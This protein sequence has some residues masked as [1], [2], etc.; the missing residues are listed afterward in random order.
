[1]HG[2]GHAHAGIQAPWSLRAEHG[3]E[4]DDFAFVVDHRATQA[5]VIG[6]GIDLD[7]GHPRARRFASGGG[8]DAGGHGVAAAATVLA[9]NGDGVTDGEVRLP[10]NIRLR[11]GDGLGGFEQGQAESRIDADD[12]G[13]ESFIA[14]ALVDDHGSFGLAVQIVEA[15]EQESFG[16]VQHQGAH[17]LIGVK[18]LLHMVIAIPL[19]LE[20]FTLV[21]RGILADGAQ[22]SGGPVDCRGRWV[23]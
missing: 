10:V 4:G 11:Q 1:M 14:Q 3:G 8:N 15:G 16:G 21:G 23:A 5:A 9:E 20:N 2:A 12:L 19:L 7:K 22:G 6:E 17:R 18:N 13:L